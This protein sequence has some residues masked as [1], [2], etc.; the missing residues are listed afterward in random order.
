MGCVPGARCKVRR[1]IVT[2]FAFVC[3]AAGPALG[4]DYWP[5]PDYW[6]LDLANE[7]WYS[8]D[9][10]RWLSVTNEPW[11]PLDNIRQVI[12]CMT[13][14]GVQWTRTD[15][16]RVDAS[17][18]VTLASVE[19]EDNSGVAYSWVYS[20]ALKFIDDPL[21]VGNS[22]TNSG[23]AAGA[24]TESFQHRC[25]VERAETVTV[26]MGTFETLVL[27]ET[28]VQNTHHDGTYYLA[29][30]W[31]PVVLPGG[32]KLVYAHWTIGVESTSWGSVKALFR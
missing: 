5:G 25:V 31:G 28:D 26:P 6:P 16:F 8:D 10:G 1:M 15:M 24:T 19:Y 11:W 12:R 21:S 20:P 3:V 27:V 7:Y 23:I 18:D 2:L 30:E 32:F 13:D 29:R 22:W 9:N 4:F 14:E 17:G